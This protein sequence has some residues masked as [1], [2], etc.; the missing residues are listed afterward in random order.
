MKLRTLTGLLGIAA[1]MTLFLALTVGQRADAEPPPAGQRLF[2][3]N[4]CNA[5]HG[6]T[7]AGIKPKM[8]SS[9]LQGP[10]LSGLRGKK[11]DQVLAFVMGESEINGR[12]HAKPFKGTDEELQA[13]VDWL[14]SL[15]AQE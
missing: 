9:R 15:E 5:C 1:T 2:L 10:D 4:S 6:V 7:A 12:K 13:I 3:A 14:A 8:S 11:S